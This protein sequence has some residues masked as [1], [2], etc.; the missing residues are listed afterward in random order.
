MKTY[1]VAVVTKHYKYIEVEAENEQQA[2]D[3]GW[4][5]VSR[6]DPLDGADIDCEL[7]AELVPEVNSEV[8]E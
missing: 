7:F 4:E 1:T 8:T 6:N 3:L 5:W 2:E